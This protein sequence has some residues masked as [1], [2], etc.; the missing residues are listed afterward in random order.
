VVSRSARAWTFSNVGL[1]ENIHVWVM[2]LPR[3]VIPP[4]DQ[5]IVV[6]RPLVEL[7][8]VDLALERLA[9]P[10]VPPGWAREG[11]TP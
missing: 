5:V 6:V 8:P 1:T 7:D 9:Q 3:A 11:S 2:P 10:S 4:G